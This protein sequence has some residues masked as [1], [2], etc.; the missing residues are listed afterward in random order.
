[1]SGSTTSTIV[2]PELA[3]L[4]LPEENSE[5]SV[6]S[7]EA[8]VLSWEP[9]GKGDSMTWLLAN[10]GEDEPGSCA[11]TLSWTSADGSMEDTG[12]F[13]IP[14]DELPTDLP[15]EGCPV[16]LEFSRGRVGTLDPGIKL[17]SIFG[18]QN[19]KVQLTLKP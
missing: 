10:L 15:A 2:M 19:Y 1:M 6:S 17:G 8:L 13:V 3:P 16:V 14:N 11:N 12:S 7:G 5:F 18:Y 4:T 9:L